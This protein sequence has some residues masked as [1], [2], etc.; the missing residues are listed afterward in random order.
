VAQVF[1]LCLHRRDA[2]ATRPFLVLGPQE[3]LE[4]VAGKR[5][6]YRRAEPALR[7]H[8]E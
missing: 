8:L 5:S 2:C 6:I 7:S 4:P 3:P 1:N